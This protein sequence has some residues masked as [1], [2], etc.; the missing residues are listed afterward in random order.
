MKTRAM[1]LA[2]A[3][4]LAA[5][6]GVSAQSSVDKAFTANGQNC[7]EINWSAEA[8]AKYPKIA[9]ACQEVM[10]RDGKTY[11]KFT[12]EVKKVAKKGT[13]VTIAMKGGNTVTLNPAP[14]RNVYI[15][16]NKV[17]VKN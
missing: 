8:L 1:I 11:A 3:V 4:A 2:A 13:E 12:G 16:G 17:P 15:G 10:Q 6:A 9:S 7:L 5:A 14:D